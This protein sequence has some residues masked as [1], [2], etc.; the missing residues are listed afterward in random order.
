MENKEEADTGFVKS[1]KR[2]WSYT[3]DKERIINRLQNLA[4]EKKIKHGKLS[5]HCRCLLSGVFYG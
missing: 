4:I 1:A 5:R 3:T 2:T